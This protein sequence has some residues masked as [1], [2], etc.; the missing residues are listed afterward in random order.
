MNNDNIF[1]A[2][3]AG[4]AGGM[5][6]SRNNPSITSTDYDAITAIA[7]TFAAELDSLIPTIGCADLENKV[8]IVNLCFAAFVNRLYTSLTG[9]NYAQLAGQIAAEYNSLVATVAGD[10]TKYKQFN[11]AAGALG[12]L[13]SSRN[14]LSITAAHYNGLSA[15]GNA[16]GKEAYALHPGI[17]T[18]IQIYAWQQICFAA[19]ANRGYN[20]STLADYAALCNQLNAVH[21]ALVTEFV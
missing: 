16:F 20:S 11:G 7:G 19:W 12:G 13:V 3:L 18:D 9:S 21:V 14:D 6:A 5:L 1:N 17:A 8:A 2:A 4:A 10:V 15:V